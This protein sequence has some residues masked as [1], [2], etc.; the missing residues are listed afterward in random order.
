MTE[1]FQAPLGVIETTHPSASAATTEVVPA[2]KA[3]SG[4]IPSPVRS[5]PGAP[6]RVPG[7]VRHASRK[8]LNGFVLPWKG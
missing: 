3:S 8:A 5:C 2:R 6:V 1:G 7:T 4:V